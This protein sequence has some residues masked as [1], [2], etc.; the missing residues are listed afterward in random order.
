MEAALTKRKYSESVL[1]K[2]SYFYYVIMCNV[3]FNLSAKLLEC[4]INIVSTNLSG[5]V[6]ML[7]IKL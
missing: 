6:L 7:Q 5:I 1:Q 4:N 2:S 3:A